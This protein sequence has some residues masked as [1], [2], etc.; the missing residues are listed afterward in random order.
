MLK[1]LSLFLFFLC[2][3]DSVF[4]ERISLNHP[5]PYV[6]MH[7]KDAVEWQRWDHSVLLK[8][9]QE[10]K[11]IFIS[12]GYYSC[13]W[14]HVMQRESF[15]DSEVAAI[16]NNYFIPVKIDRELEPVLD[17]YLL[18]Y[19][20]KTQGY[21]G[22][23]L[24]MFVSP[25]GYPLTGLVYL[26]KDDLV[27]VLNRTKQKWKSDQ[28]ELLK[29]AKDAFDYT[30][31]IN[32][33]RV[34][35]DKAEI[36]E[37]FLRITETEIDGFDGGFGEQQKF[38]RPYLM[39]ALLDVYANFEQLNKQDQ[40]WLEEF[41]LITL[42]SISERGLHD[43]V[44]GGFFRYTVDQGWNAPHF[45]KMLYT[46]AAM[47]RLYVKA[48]RVFGDK[49]YLKIARE[50][51]DFLMREMADGNGGFVSALSAQDGKLRDGGVYA[52][53]E[54]MLEQALTGSELAWY[55]KNVERVPLEN[56]GEHLP[57]G[58][59]QE[60]ES[61]R[62]KRK[63]LEWRSGNPA[64]RDSKFVLAWNAY[65]LTSMI[66]LVEVTGDQVYRQAA[67]ALK[68][69][70]LK[71]Y[72][73]AN[74]AQ[75]E[76]RQLLDDYVQLADAIYRWQRLQG[77]K[78]KNRLV[79]ELLEQVFDLFVNKH[80]WKSSSTSIIP[81]PTAVANVKD[82]NLPAADVVCLS[83]IRSLGGAYSERMRQLLDEPGLIDQRVLTQP[84][85]YASY[86][87]GELRVI[88]LQKA[89]KP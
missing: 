26:P 88:S 17:E 27:D 70:L 51:L 62:V 66:D 19:M 9:Q 30:V 45:E 35:V 15:I 37:N 1:P 53:S 31:V 16:L 46:N 77:G 2:Y 76:G 21:G 81:M 57:V 22:W 73:A 41:L 34:K 50:T 85:K 54:E 4:A 32:N 24:N 38:P 48:Y 63:L 68:A 59:W 79:E 13:H 42:N 82:G 40:E 14:C 7:A 56:R 23:P 61:L 60:G 28:K 84:L 55:R 10:N 83:L 58:L 36:V 3:C 49:K 52:W 64:L 44:G 12:S 39:M 80:G 20:H 65:L 8:A 25:Q 71:E 72:Q 86:I 6:R 89:D 67:V 69:R 33:K 75:Q 78:R 43:A 11:L 29:I 74:G 5:S 47:I 87:A 18:D